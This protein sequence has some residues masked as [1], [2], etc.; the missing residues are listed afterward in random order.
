MQ[1]RTPLAYVEA[2]ASPNIKSFSLFCEGARPMMAVLLNKPA[3][4]TSV[5]VTWNFAAGLVDVPVIRATEEGTFWQASLNSSRLIAMLMRQTGSA[6]LRINGRLE[7]EAS[8]AGAPTA[9]RGAMR[10]CARH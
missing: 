10:T 1:G 9:L 2:A 8:L 3:T 7:G 4:T 6:M 5:T